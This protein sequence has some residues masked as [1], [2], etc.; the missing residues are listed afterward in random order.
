V[1]NKCLCNIKYSLNLFGWQLPSNGLNLD[2]ICKVLELVHR[3]TRN[4][5]V[6]E[7]RTFW[8]EFRMFP[9]KE[10][11]TWQRLWNCEIDYDP[12]YT[13]ILIHIVCIYILSFTSTTPYAF[14]VLSFR[15]LISDILWVLCQTYTVSKTL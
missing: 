3:T 1:H 2:G 12:S 14:S 10:R 11:T 13:Y 7:I 15:I 4:A 9:E 8:A 6:Y 5:H